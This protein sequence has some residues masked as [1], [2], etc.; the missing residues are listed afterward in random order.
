MAETVH[1]YL[2]AAGGSPR[3]GADTRPATRQ[4]EDLMSMGS[5]RAIK[6]IPV[7]QALVLRRFGQ[8]LTLWVN[9]QSE[10]AVEGKLKADLPPVSG[11]GYFEAASSL[12]TGGTPVTLVLE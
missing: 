1:L 6:G 8:P 4:Y 10:Q 12:A 3:R 5:I 11:F 7:S 9:P 2:K